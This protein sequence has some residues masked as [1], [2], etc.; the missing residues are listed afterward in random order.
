M[1]KNNEVKEKDI[2][3]EIEK[4]LDQLEEFHLKEKQKKNGMNLTNRYQKI[5]EKSFN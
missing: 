2:Y 5:V 1:N 3:K 4:K